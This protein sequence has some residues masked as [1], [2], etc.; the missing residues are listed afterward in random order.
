MENGAIKF[1]VVSAGRK[2]KMHST[3]GKD[4]VA[5][6]CGLYSF[7]IRL[8]KRRS[9]TIGSQVLL[10]YRQQGFRV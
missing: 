3:K 7:R 5:L 1:S 4:R 8:G 2:V 6:P 10:V 9:H